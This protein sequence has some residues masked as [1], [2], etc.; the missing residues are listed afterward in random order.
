MVRALR[1]L[2]GTVLA[3]ALATM[4]MA[5]DPVAVITEIRAEGGQIEV[6]RAGES[7]WGAAQPLQAL[8]AG[9]QLRAAGAARAAV[10][11]TGGRGAQSVAAANSPFTVQPPATA[12]SGE[13]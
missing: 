12:A 1:V 4:A 7:S 8:R 13:K 6:K 3:L 2:A 9:G 10:V 5:A 11:F